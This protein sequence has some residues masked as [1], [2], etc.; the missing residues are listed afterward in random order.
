[1][2]I[3]VIKHQ[4]KKQL[5]GGWGLFPVAIPGDCWLL[6]EATVGTQGRKLDARIEADHGG[7]LLTA[8][9]SNDSLSCIIQDHQGWHYPQCSGTSHI[10]HQSRKLSLRKFFPDD[11]S[12]CQVVKTL[13]PAMAMSKPFS[14]THKILTPRTETDRPSWW[15]HIWTEDYRL[16]RPWKH[17]QDLTLL[18][19]SEGRE[20]LGWDSILTSSL[21]CRPSLEPPPLPALP[22]YRN[23]SHRSAPPLKG[24]ESTWMDYG[25]LV[26]SELMKSLRTV[27]GLPGNKMGFIRTVL[28]S[29]SED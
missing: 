29:C 24:L 9:F 3:T 16:C 12:L 5:L 15:S 8:L 26:Y 7:T 10:N 11:S 4:G 19:G 18:G 27:L 17:Q 2:S 21:M 25:N 6:R 1:M 23:G 13:R 22:C 14:K 28:A 20:E